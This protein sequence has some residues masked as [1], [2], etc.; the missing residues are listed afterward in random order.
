MIT[1][2]VDEDADIPKI[3]DW[4]NSIFS[5]GWFNTYVHYLDV[6]ELLWHYQRR[7]FVFLHSE[8]ATFFKLRWGGKIADM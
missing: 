1:V 2:I 8:D 4:C 3:E 7:C 6:N 5:S